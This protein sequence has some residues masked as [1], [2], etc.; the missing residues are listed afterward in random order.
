MNNTVDETFK[1]KIQRVDWIGSLLFIT[2]ITS[3]LI[4][5]C[6]GGI[7]FKWSSAYTIVPV[8]FGLYSIWLCA[9]WEVRFPEPVL[10][11]SLFCNLSAVAAYYCAFAQGFLV[12]FT[13]S[14]F[15]ISVI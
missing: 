9:V 11:G 7:Q 2:G 3:I 6:W 13:P 1:Q 5:I 10:R 12:S 4:G 14:L 8:V 15:D